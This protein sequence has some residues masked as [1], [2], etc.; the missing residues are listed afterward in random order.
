MEEPELTSLQKTEKWMY[1]HPKTTILLLFFGLICVGILIGAGITVNIYNSE[2]TR[3]L[4]ETT[5]THHPVLYDGRVYSIEEITVATSVR[6]INIT[7]TTN[8]TTP[9]I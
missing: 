5:E 6:I 4:A 2:I 1:E 3:L 9:W 8:A 7:R